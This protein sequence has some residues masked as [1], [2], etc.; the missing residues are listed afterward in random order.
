M[1]TQMRGNIFVG[2]PCIGK[3]SIA[4]QDNIIDLDSSTFKDSMGIR[5]A[6]WVEVYVNI[7]CSLVKQG[8]KVFLSSH[9]LVTEELKKRD[10][11]FTIF[12]PSLDMHQAWIDRATKR[13]EQSKSE[14][15]LMAL[16]RIKDYF[17]EDIKALIEMDGPSKVI[18]H[19]DIYNLKDLI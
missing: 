8:Y 2:Y 7:A 17:E 1:K 13:Y 16:K 14:K 19:S 9:F 12:C 10:L 3:T 18:I 4:G 11:P 6:S 5:Y 15:D